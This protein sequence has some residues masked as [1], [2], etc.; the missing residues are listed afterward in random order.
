MKTKYFPS[1][2]Q[3]IP[4]LDIPRNIRALTTAWNCR[5]F[6]ARYPFRRTVP[7]TPQAEEPETTGPKYPSWI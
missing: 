2:R 7:I 6:S 5:P 4:S 3:G 1:A